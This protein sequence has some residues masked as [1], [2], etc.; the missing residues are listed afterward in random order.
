[1]PTERLKWAS[2]PAELAALGLKSAELLFAPGQALSPRYEALESA[3]PGVRRARFPLPGTSDVHGN[4]T[5]RPGA[6]GTGWVWLTAYSGDLRALLRARWTAPRSASRAERE[7]NLLCALR[8]RGVGTCE[9]LLV[10][11]RGSGL[12]SG[13]S[14]ILV[15]E[16]E[17][18]FP[19]PRWL[20]TDGHGA[21]RALGLEAVARALQQLLRSEIVLADLMPEDLLLTP[22]GSGE[23]EADA[24]GGLRKNKFPGVTFA[25]VA[26]GRFERTLDVRRRALEPLVRALAPLVSEGER[27][28]FERA[29]LS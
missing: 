3:E 14:F 26:H 12:V 4:L 25:R 1:M 5:G 16:P 19:F 29:L 9:P 27:A 8:A 13:H 10:G 24:Q 17:G 23:C 21:E 11:A 2:G 18:A 28:P 7:W 6:L 22:S 20:R 15:R